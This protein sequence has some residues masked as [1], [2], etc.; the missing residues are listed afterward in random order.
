MPRPPTQSPVHCSTD[1][2]P[3][4][5]TNE[6]IERLAEIVAD[7]RCPFPEDV[8]PGDAQRLKAQVR[9]RLQ[10]R[11]VRLIARAVAAHLHREPDRPP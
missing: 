7:G 11:M 6:Q 9:Q 4:R 10:E 8:V 1:V 5:L 3:S 2:G